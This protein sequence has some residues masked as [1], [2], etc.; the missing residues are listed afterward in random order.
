MPE[1]TPLYDVTA[2][3]GAA[4]AEEAGWQVPAHFGDPAAEYA[5]ARAGAGLWDVSH[6]GKVELTGP[7]ASAFVHNLCTNDVND[8]ALGAG[9]EAFLTTNKAKVVVGPLFVFHVRLHDGRPALWLDVPPGTAEKVIQHLDRFVISEQVEFADRTREF[10]Q[11]HLAGPQATAVLE[12][13][14]LD[15]VPPLEE[16]QHMVRTFG[17]DATCHVRRHAPLGLPGYDVV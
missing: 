12:K 13:A 8:L 16:L 1:R 7:E 5:R 17:A 9:V 2:A 15:D 11:L 14:L 3:A 4:F 10:A 6:R